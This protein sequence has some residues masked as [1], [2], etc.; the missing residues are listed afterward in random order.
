ML[1]EEVVTY[2]SYYVTSLI[3]DGSQIKYSGENKK[4]INYLTIFKGAD[5]FTTDRNYEMIL[6]KKVQRKCSPTTVG[7][8]FENEPKYCSFLDILTKMNQNKSNLFTFQNE[9]T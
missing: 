7:I 3:Y 5:L 1:R 2:R 4:R 9:Q 6:V 8:V